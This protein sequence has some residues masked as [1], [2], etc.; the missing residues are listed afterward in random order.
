MGGNFNLPGFT[1]RLVSELQRQLP[2]D[3]VCRAK[4][5]SGDKS[6]T[7]WTAMAK[8]AHT[9]AYKKHELLKKT[10]LSTAWI[11]QLRNG[12]VIKIGYEEIFYYLK[13]I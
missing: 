5:S 10:I 7:G 6:L 2:T 13:E 4:I 12:L 11:G 8:F 1:D 9:D 3:W